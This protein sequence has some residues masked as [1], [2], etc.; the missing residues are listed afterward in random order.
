MGH[1]LATYDQAALIIFD[2][3]FVA[4]IDRVVLEQIGDIARRGY[5]ID[6]DQ[7]QFGR[8]ENNFQGCPTYPT[9]PFIATFAIIGSPQDVRICTEKASRLVLCLGDSS[10]IVNETGLCEVLETK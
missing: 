8:V 4:A 1:I 2:H 7:L 6:R 9:S 5:I 3:L 10:L